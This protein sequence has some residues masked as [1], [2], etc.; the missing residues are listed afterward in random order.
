MNQIMKNPAAVGAARGAGS[1]ESAAD[2]LSIHQYSDGV[3]RRA[4]CADR[5]RVAAT[6]RLEV[7]AL[8]HET[9]HAVVSV[10]EGVPVTKIA[11]WQT[12]VLGAPAWGGPACGRGVLVTPGTSPEGD[13][14][15]ARFVIGGMSGEMV[16]GLHREGSSVDELFVAQV[17]APCVAEK[18]GVDDLGTAGDRVQHGWSKE[19]NA[20]FC[21]GYILRVVGGAS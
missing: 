18:P 16:T 6:C 13:L 20:G 5:R 17:I 14:A 21:R 7:Q 11:I 2:V 19:G 9:G 15:S 4:N 3:H 10:H 1:D 12:S 8:G